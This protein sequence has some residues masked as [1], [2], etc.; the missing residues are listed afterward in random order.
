MLLNIGIVLLGISV[1]GLAITNFIAYRKRGVSFRESIFTNCFSEIEN[2]SE[3]ESYCKSIFLI[4]FI[5]GIAFVGWHI[6]SSGRI[7]DTII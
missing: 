4:L 6:S 2:P 1:C 5:T 7:L 3:L